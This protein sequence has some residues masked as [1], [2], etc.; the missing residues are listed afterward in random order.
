MESCK[1]LKLNVCR[2]TK[3]LIDD[4]FCKLIRE[5]KNKKTSK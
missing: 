5:V 1:G 2:N 3:V 4:S